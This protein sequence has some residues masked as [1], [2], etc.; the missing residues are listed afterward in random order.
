MSAA[1]HR[2]HINLMNGDVEKNPTER[3]SVFDRRRFSS[4]EHLSH[5]K[6][7]MRKSQGG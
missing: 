3:R 4:G 1:T 2:T 7:Y 6:A 5:E